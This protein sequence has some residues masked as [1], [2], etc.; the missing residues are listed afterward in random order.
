MAAYCSLMNT[1]PAQ[2]PQAIP[3]WIGRRRLALVAVIGFGSTY[4][5]AAA[6]EFETSLNDLVR[7][8]M[9]VLICASITFWCWYDSRIRGARLFFTLR[10]LIFLLGIV[11]DAIYFWQSRSHKQCGHV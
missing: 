4:G 9:T 7:V 5:A 8:L 10:V 1:T 3:N 6:F 11:G 2:L